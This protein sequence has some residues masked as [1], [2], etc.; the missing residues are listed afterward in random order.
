MLTDFYTTKV[1]FSQWLHDDFP[2]TWGELDRILTREAVEHSLLP[3]TNDYWCRDY[4]PIP[5]GE[6]K[7]AAYD[8]HPDYLKAKSNQRYVTD[9]IP[10]MN[11]IGL[12]ITKQTNL[13]IDGG[14]VIRCDDA[15][16]MTEKVLN[17]NPGKDTVKLLED[18]FGCKVVFLPWDRNERYGHADGIVRYIGDGRVL[19]TNYRDFDPEMADRMY[20]ILS[21]HFDVVRLKYEGAKH[22]EHSWAYINFL[23]T[24][25]IVIVP[26]YGEPEDNQALSQI[27]DA[28]PG[29]KGKVFG[30]RFNEITRMGGGV[31]CV[32]WNI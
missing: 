32:S 1:F 20:G 17:E 3:R 27:E 23:Q 28:L 24:R 7:Y 13:V 21:E 31:N 11:A 22:H 8:Y 18:L 12:P 9:P 5:V 26:T 14:N 30:V 6:G 19:M 29:Y 10:V 16:I 15:V 4:M 2:K 25:D